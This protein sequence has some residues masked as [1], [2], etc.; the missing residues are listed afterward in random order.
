MTSEEIIIKLKLIRHPEG[1]WFRETYRSDETAININGLAR[2][3]CT[4][5]FY[6]LEKNDK[7]HFHRL[8]SDEIWFFHEGV[9]IEIVMITNGKFS[10]TII[11]N[12]IAREQI[13][14]VIIPAGTWFGARLQSPEGYALVSCTV[15]PGFDF[16]DF[17]MGKREEMMRAFP[18]L[19]K[20]IQEFT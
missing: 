14:Q 5:I 17:E 18:D 3:A 10:S 20:Q 12:E 7:S 4:A 15:S 2:N 6:M 11:G 1:G 8:T 19:E 9:P 16:D 13:P